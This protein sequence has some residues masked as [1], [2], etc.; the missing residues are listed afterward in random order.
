MFSRDSCK[1]FGWLDRHF[2]ISRG[3]LNAEYACPGELAEAVVLEAQDGRFGRF[4]AAGGVH[5]AGRG[6]PAKPES[7][8]QLAGRRLER[9]QM[10]GSYDTQAIDPSAVTRGH[11]SEPTGLL[12]YL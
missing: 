8:N 12:S 11:R 10:V 7:L 3:E 4:G 5:Q 9:S 1:T 2:A 6:T